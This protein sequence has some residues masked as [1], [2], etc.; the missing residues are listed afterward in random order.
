MWMPFVVVKLTSIITSV[1]AYNR[2]IA[3]TLHPNYPRGE[4]RVE[5]NVMTIITRS[6]AA[7]IESTHARP[8]SHYEINYSS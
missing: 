4:E 5:N 8:T 6:E 3:E 1:I 2:S 7:F